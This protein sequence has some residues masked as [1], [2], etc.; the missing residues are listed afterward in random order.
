MKGYSKLYIESIIPMLQ[1]KPFLFGR[2]KIKI[3]DYIG[4]FFWK[5][6]QIQYM[7][8]LNETL[9]HNNID[10]FVYNNGETGEIEVIQC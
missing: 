1:T 4:F 3:L 10:V 6:D 5:D 8:Y 7:N 2:D 9:R